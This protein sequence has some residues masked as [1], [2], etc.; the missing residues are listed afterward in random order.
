MI[1]TDCIGSCKSNDHDGPYHNM[2]NNDLFQITDSNQV[3][4]GHKLD[5][6]DVIPVVSQS[7]T[8][9][10]LDNQNYFII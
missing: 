4:P 6:P 10:Y 1:D 9:L 8:F 2:I 7:N 3:P 5:H